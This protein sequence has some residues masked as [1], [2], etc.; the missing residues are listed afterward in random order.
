MGSTR[1]GN[2]LTYYKG[3]AGNLDILPLLE[4]RSFPI[5]CL[6]QCD[7]NHWPYR[8]YHCSISWTRQFNSCH[9]WSKSTT[10]PLPNGIYHR[11]GNGLQ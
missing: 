5:K 1:A 11:K 9:I 8:N 7:G 6:R 2:S 3:S 4:T 10:D